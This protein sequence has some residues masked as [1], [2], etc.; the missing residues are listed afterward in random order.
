M[1]AARYTALSARKLDADHIGE[2]EVQM[3]IDEARRHIGDDNV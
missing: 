2:F 3:G 1:A